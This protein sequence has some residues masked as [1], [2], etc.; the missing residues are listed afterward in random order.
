M[1]T[2][3]SVGLKIGLLAATVIAIGATNSALAQTPAA[4]KGGT[5]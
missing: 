5:N 3:R 4:P 1:H 2:P